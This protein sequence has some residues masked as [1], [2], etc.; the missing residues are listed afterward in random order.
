VGVV[1]GGA[2]RA[3]QTE[4]LGNAQRGAR[5]AARDTRSDHS[6]SVSARFCTARLR[7]SSGIIALT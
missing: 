2:R 5:Y 1:A 6:D 7:I 4:P 3:G